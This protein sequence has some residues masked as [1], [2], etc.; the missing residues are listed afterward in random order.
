MI[1]R[2]ASHYVRHPLLRFTLIFTWNVFGMVLMYHVLLMGNPN[3]LYVIMLAG[4]MGIMGFLMMLHNA[5][6][7]R[8]RDSEA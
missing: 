7:S 8:R 6:L 2:L 5:S 4:F 3:Q 1:D